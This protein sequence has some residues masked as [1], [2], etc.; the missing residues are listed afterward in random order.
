MEMEIEFCKTEMEMDFFL[1]KRK[2]KWNNIFRRNKR[3]NEISVSDRYRISVFK[4]FCMVNLADPIHNLI[5]SNHLN[6]TCSTPC[7]TKQSC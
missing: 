5:I 7:Y 3:G 2:R 1:W 6:N 4:W